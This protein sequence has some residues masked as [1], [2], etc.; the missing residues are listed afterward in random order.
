MVHTSHYEHSQKLAHRKYI[1]YV[2]LRLDAEINAENTE[3]TKKSTTTPKMT[4]AKSKAATAKTQVKK[5]KAPSV[6]SWN[7]VDIEDFEESEE[8]PTKF[9]LMH[10]EEEVVFMR[11]ENRQLNDRLSGLEG[12]LQEVITHLKRQTV[13]EE[14]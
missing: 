5:E 4:A 1:R 10:L 8:E 7:P 13:K 14:Q 3:A 12:A 11:Q 6:S 9:A 2:E